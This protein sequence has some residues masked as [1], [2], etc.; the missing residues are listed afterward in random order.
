MLYLLLWLSRLARLGLWRLRL[1]LRALLL[2]LLL[3]LLLSL[4]LLCE[5]LSGLFLLHLDELLRCHACF[6]GLLLNL[7]SLKGLKLRNSHA[8]LLCLHGDHLLDGLRVELLRP[9]RPARRRTSRRHV[10]GG[11]Q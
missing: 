6:G 11:R 3:L 7:L 10:G 1:T 5:L 2:L 4:L 8:S 9:A